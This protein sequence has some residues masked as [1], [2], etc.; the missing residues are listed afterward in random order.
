MIVRKDIWEIYKVKGEFRDKVLGGI[1]ADEKL[2]E[3]SLIRKGLEPIEIETQ[4]R[5][6]E[7]TMEIE[8]VEGATKQSTSLFFIDENGV[9]LRN[10]QLMG[11]LKEAMGVQK[12]IT[13][14]RYKMQNGVRVAPQNIYL[15]DAKGNPIYKFDGFL[16]TPIHVD[17]K[18]IPQ[19]SIKN[20]AYVTKPHFEFEVWI[21]KERGKAIIDRNT[22]EGLLAQSQELGIGAMRRMGYGQWDATLVD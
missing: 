20:V 6:L 17:N 9:M 12:A 7:K 5:L 21:A 22:L 1:A 14:W 13:M 8:T 16:Q 11:A 10:Y 2:L 3:S 15:T 18:G 4:K 19:T